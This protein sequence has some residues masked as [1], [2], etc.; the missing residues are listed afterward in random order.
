MSRGRIQSF[1]KEQMLYI[2]DEKQKGTILFYYIG[3][4]KNIIHIKDPEP[5]KAVLE[6]LSRAA[7]SN[8]EA[9]AAT[10]IEADNQFEVIGFTEV[11]RLEKYAH[12]PWVTRQVQR[13][14]D[15]ATTGKTNIQ[16]VSKKAPAIQ[17]I[18]KSWVCVIQFPFCETEYTYRCRRQHAVGINIPNRLVKVFSRKENKEIIVPV[19]KCEL[20]TESRIK[21]EAKKLGYSDLTTVASDD[22]TQEEYE[23]WE[24]DNYEE[25]INELQAIKECFMPRCDYCS[26]PTDSSVFF[27]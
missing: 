3:M 16:L 9:V 15:L 22:V 26:M 2:G 12:M 20:W 27:D 23:Q 10:F 17:T 21:E 19:L 25:D 18:E 11:G 5:V 13:A 6:A 24:S 4:I 14:R 7:A 8:K 1:G